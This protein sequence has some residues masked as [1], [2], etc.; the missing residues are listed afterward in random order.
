MNNLMSVFTNLRQ[1][2]SVKFA[3]EI[4]Y[5]FPGYWFVHIGKYNNNKNYVQ[6]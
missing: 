6:K 3:A 2:A 5:G 4:E 1:T